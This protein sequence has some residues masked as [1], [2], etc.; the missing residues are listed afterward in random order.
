[1]SVVALDPR[2]LTATRLLPTDGRE[3]TSWDASSP[4][5]ARRWHGWW[6][7]TARTAATPLLERVVGAG[8]PRPQVGGAEPAGARSP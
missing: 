4:P 1:M 3:P 8:G 5:V 6:N 7:Q 2:A